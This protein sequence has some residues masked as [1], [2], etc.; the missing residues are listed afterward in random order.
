MYPTYDAEEK[1]I[2]L[3]KEMRRSVLHK[4]EE[5]NSFSYSWAA[6]SIDQ[7]EKR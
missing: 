1:G 6:Q 3:A 7:L 5:K 4:K 2:L